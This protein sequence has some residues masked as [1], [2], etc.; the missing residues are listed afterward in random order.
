[1]SK[2]FE[3]LRKKMSPQSRER[4]RAVAQQ[5]RAQLK[6]AEPGPV[7]SGCASGLKHPVNSGFHFVLRDE[8]TA[9]RL[10]QAFLYGGAKARVP[11]EQAQGNT[12]NQLL[13]IGAGLTGDLGKLRFLL[14]GEVD[15]HGG[16]LAESGTLSTLMSFL[17]SPHVSQRTRD[18]RH[19][20]PLLSL[21]RPFH[22]SKIRA[23]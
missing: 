8:F 9:V 21:T 5:Y 22:R 17:R 20:A 13:G 10:L 12:L 14:R 19:P 7:G 6:E 1:M 23:Q 18:M 2:G 15:F 16:S 3:T 4:S 11:F